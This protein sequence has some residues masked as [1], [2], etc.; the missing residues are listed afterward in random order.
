MIM[1]SGTY[2]LG[3]PI[4]DA[5]GARG[6]SRLQEPL[7]REV[8]AAGGGRYA[9]ADSEA[10]VR[11]LRSDLQEL[12]LLPEPSPGDAT[13]AWARYDLSFLLGLGAL[14]LILTESLLDMTL[15]MRRSSP[16]REWA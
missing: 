5:S 7:L 11:A 14:L 6:T 1:P 3:G 9:N 12:G 13:P 2:Q 8:A 16:T 10:E 4:L 15:S